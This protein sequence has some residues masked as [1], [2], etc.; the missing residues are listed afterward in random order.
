MKPT[1]KLTIARQFIPLV[2]VSLVT[3][4]ITYVLIYLGWG[5]EVATEF[6]EGITLWAMNHIFPL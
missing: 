2:L 6:R 4:P 1:S 3:L 5:K